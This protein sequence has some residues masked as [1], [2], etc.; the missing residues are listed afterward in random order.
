MKPRFFTGF[1]YSLL[2]L[3]VFGAL[4]SICETFGMR[5]LGEAMY[6]SSTQAFFDFVLSIW[7]AVSVAMMVQRKKN[8][9]ALFNASFGANIVVILKDSYESPWE[10]AIVVAL[11]IAIYWFYNRESVR[12]YLKS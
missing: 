1:S 9:L 3:F 7:G 11:T 2:V 4:A 8:G 10:I 12:A 6:E 5:P